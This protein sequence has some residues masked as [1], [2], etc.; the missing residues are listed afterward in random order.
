MKKMGQTSKKPAFKYFEKLGLLAGFIVEFLAT[1]FADDQ[2]DYHL[3]YKTELKKKLRE[4]FSI[5]DEFLSSR[6][7]WQNFYKEKFNWTVDFSSVIVP[8]IP[9]DGKWRLLFIPKGMTMNLAFKIALSLFKSWKY[10]DD[11]DKKVTKNIRNTEHHYAVWVRDGVEPD[12]EFFGQST[13][14]ADPEMLIGVTLLERILFEIKY[15]IETGSHLDIKGVTFCSGS[16]YADG[17]VPN[18][19]LNNDDKFNV[20]Y[21][22]LDT[23]N[24]KYGIRREVF[25]LIP[26]LVGIC[27]SVY[28]DQPFVIFD[29]SCKFSSV[30]K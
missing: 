20:N 12:Q 15:F 13:R 28:F 23:S 29:I 8:V 6:E 2:I 9:S 25:H 3:G 26:T 16:R 7:E 19:Y 1:I 27:V 18:A 30:F 5:T 11:L 22:S 10:Y 24:S 4:V 17:Y 14:Q 21:Y